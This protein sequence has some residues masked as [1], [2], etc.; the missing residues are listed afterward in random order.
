MFIAAPFGTGKT[1]FVKYTVI[2]MAEYYLSGQDN[3]IPIYL[4]LNQKQKFGIIYTP[5]NTIY[6]DLNNDI[7]PQDEKVLIVCD[8]LDE[9]HE[10]DKIASLK[11]DLLTIQSK[12]SIS[13]LKIIFT[14]RLEAGFPQKLGIKKFVRLLPFT[15]NQVA[16]FF[17]KY[18]NQDL[19]FEDIS[20]Y[21]LQEKNKDSS[22]QLDLL[23]PLFCWMFAL[24]YNDLQVIKDVD[25][26]I[27]RFILYST[28]IHSIL[29]GRYK[30]TPLQIVKE[31]WILRK[32]AALKTI[33]EQAYE[34][35]LPKLLQTF[36]EGEQQEIIN[37]Q[38]IN[39]H[40][41]LTSYF[42]LNEKSNNKHS[43]DFLHKSFQE[44]L[45][46]EYYIESALLHN[47]IFRIS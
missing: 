45:L 7:K 47:S 28:F 39:L 12:F 38:N 24:S 29:E 43:V 9:Y 42:K 32:I 30:G 17:I 35:D 3:W 1:S 15:T 6:Q 18:G 27:A 36:I 20:K 10:S 41:V 11:E 5:D 4:P 26:G 21:G 2:K 33:F 40:T 31:K 46:A 19:V 13:H 8:G 16:D 37:L 14:T 44:Y 25:V 34:E 22:Y 23:K